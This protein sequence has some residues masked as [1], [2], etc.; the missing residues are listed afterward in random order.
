MLTRTRKRNMQATAYLYLMFDQVYGR[1]QAL[2][3]Y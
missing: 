3:V 2:E 1:K